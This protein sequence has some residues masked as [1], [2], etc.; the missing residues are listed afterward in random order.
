MANFSSYQSIT[1]KK[2]ENNK[3][4]KHENNNKLQQEPESHSSKSKSPLKFILLS[5]SRNMI[6][7]SQEHTLP[8][9]YVSRS[10]IVLFC[11]SFFFLF[12]LV[13]TCYLFLVV[14]GCD[15]VF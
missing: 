13:F 1:K 11:F 9:S 7:S 3:F 15:R 8:L 10:S 12:Q 14:V 2:K 4:T 6:A 5:R